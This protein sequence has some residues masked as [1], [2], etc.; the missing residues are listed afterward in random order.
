MEKDKVDVIVDMGTR[1]IRRYDCGSVAGV[2]DQFE[3]CTS[4]ESLGSRLLSSFVLLDDQS[5]LFW[6]SVQQ[7]RNLEINLA[8]Q[9]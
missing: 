1:N 6:G 2:A 3:N 7:L 8:V 5:I 4:V 9:K